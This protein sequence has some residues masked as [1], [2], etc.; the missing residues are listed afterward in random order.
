MDHAIFSI[1]LQRKMRTPILAKT[2]EINT[3][4]VIDGLDCDFV[5]FPALDHTFHIQFLIIHCKAGFL[6]IEWAILSL[7]SLLLWFPQIGSCFSENGH[8]CIRA[9]DCWGLGR[10]G[11]TSESGAW[12]TLESEGF[13]PVISIQIGGQIQKLPGLT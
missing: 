8:L 9:H 1:P 3:Y 12:V 6:R 13:H 4:P 5:V 10:P 2:S 11:G 7:D